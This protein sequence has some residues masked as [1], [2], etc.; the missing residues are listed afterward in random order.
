[1][2]YGKTSEEIAQDLGA[3][4]VVYQTLDGL[5]EAIGQPNLCTGCLTG[6][7]PTDVKS[8][9]DFQAMRLKDRAFSAKVKGC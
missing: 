4:R 8:G 2:A 5:K 3:D 7:Y 9:E 6:E 1:V